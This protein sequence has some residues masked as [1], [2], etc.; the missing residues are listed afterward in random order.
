MAD[1]EPNQTVIEP[2]GSAIVVGPNRAVARIHI[3]TALAM[4]AA[5]VVACAAVD[6]CAHS[7]RVAEWLDARA[8]ISYKRYNRAYNHTRNYGD[9]FE[10]LMLDELPKADYSKGGVYVLGSSNVMFCADFADLAP[11]QARLIH[12]YGFPGASPAEIFQF[13]RFLVENEGF[14]TAGPGKTEVLLSL[15]ENDLLEAGPWGPGAGGYFPPYLNASGFYHYD[16]TGGISVVPMSPVERFFKLRKNRWRS[17][18]QRCGR[19]LERT[20]HSPVDMQTRR[21]EAM[22]YG[23]SDDWSAHPPPQLKELAR[24]LD[25]LKAKGVKVQFLMVPSGH[26]NDGV[27]LHENFV[28]AIPPLCA[29]RGIPLLDY[30]RLLSDDE[31]MDAHHASYKGAL[32]LHDAMVRLALEH[33]YQTGAL[34]PDTRKE[35]H[36]Q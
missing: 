33:L 12:D 6:F 18:L 31:F 16:P 29:A 2:P 35:S 26:W 36:G 8:L 19:M 9:P 4:L 28:A 32:K 24:L 3:R 1:A 30:S 17:F 13:V 23:A 11:E 34:P 7:R 10:F 5:V 14:L 25:Y 21:V 20:A 15:C 22:R 27:P